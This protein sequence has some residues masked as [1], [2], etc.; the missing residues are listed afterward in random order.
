MRSLLIV[1][2][3]FAIALQMAPAA[4]NMKA[5]PPP[6]EG[7]I[8]Y[9]LPLV[10]EKDEDSLKVEL[11]VGKTVKVDA[12]NRYFFGGT[13]ETVNIEGW[14]FDYRIL[15]K[16]GPM[17]GTLMAVDP[18]VLKVDRFIAIG[19]E[20][21]LLRYNSRLPLVIYVPE[22]VEVRYRVWRAGVELKKVD[23]G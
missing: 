2:A 21:Q 5:F 7:M 18:N 19:G 4:D 12:A 8:R 22:G 9:V 13:L 17:A 3:H 16:L 14:G 1:F 23:K 11:V 10:S 20:P 6:A 15:R